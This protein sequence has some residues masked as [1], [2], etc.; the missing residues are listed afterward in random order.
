MPFH[1]RT[2]TFKPRCDSCDARSP[3]PLLLLH[4]QQHSHHPFFLVCCTPLI[5][6]L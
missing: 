1:A 4:L 6:T 2:K 3:F 5:L